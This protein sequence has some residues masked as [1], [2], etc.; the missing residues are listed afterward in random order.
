MSLR[1][2]FALARGPLQLE[3]DLTVDDAE[4]LA[5][6]GPNGAGKT[7]CLH[8]VAGLLRI[9][10][11]A[12]ELDG[13]RLDGGPGAP[14]VPPERRRAGMV[15]QDH[16]LF[17]H[18]STLDN[19]AYGLRARGVG[20]TAARAAAHTWLQRVGLAEFAARPPHAL[21][22]GQAQRAALARALA[23]TPRLL[24]LDEPLS[25]V[26]ATARQRLRRDLGE[27]LRAFAGPRLLVTHDAVDAFAL[28]DR[29]AVLEHGRVVQVGT[30]AAI[31][32]SPRSRYVADLIGRNFFR[33]VVGADGVFTLADGSQL[34]VATA[35]R[36]AAIATAHPRA[37]ALFP[38]RPAGSP[39]NT[40]L[41]T[42]AAVEPSFDSARIRLD[43]HVPLIAEVTKGTVD[44]MRLRPG[45]PIWVALKA[46]EIAV[47]AE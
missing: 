23:A 1:L 15:F 20:R 6:V 14:F 44:S 29:I 25:A 38:E 39:R 43:G 17:P 26:D 27:H 10:R 18:R 33:G 11:G 45:L 4:T 37:I 35:I 7:T 19:V 21:S 34:V 16:L 3:L 31:A 36:G 8:A 41:A 12:I 13:E 22:G 40:W 47:E 2:A 28:A 9:E 24:L 30:A 5:L 32:A 42:I 46:T